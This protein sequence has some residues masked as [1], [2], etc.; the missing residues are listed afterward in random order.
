MDECG[1]RGKLFGFGG[2]GEGVCVCCD[3]GDI[4]LLDDEAVRGDWVTSQSLSAVCWA[5]FFFF[6]CF[7]VEEL[8]VVVFD[9]VERLRRLAVSAMVNSKGV[10]GSS[11]VRSTW[12]GGFGFVVERRLAI[13]CV[14]VASC[15]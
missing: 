13:S 3:K 11:S 8:E 4:W 6:F 14:A 15:S 5:F 7:L 10:D 12:L 9:S 2:R 1:L